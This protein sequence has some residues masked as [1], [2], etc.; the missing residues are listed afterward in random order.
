MQVPHFECVAPASNWL[1]G[2]GGPEFI[3]REAWQPPNFLG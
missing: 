1:A 3:R 2:F